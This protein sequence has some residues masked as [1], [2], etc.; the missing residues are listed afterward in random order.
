[1]NFVDRSNL[2]N[3]VNGV[4]AKNTVKCET[5]NKSYKTLSILKEHVKK[6]HENKVPK[7]ECNKCNK[8]FY[9]QKNFD[10][11][12]LLKHMGVRRYNCGLCDKNFT[13]ESGLKNH[14]DFSRVIRMPIKTTLKDSAKTLILLVGL[15][16]LM[17][18][19]VSDI[20]S[21]LRV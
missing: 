18:L 20:L 9:R 14:L 1:M 15:M 17:A 10:T 12:V 7:K 21:R 2:K 4:H 13:Y 5:C 16:K 19:Y 8:T 11:H 6:V 3:H